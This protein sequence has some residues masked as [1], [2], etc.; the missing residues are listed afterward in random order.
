MKR[1]WLLAGTIGA[2]LL[3]AFDQPLTLAAGVVILLGFVAAG[4]VLVAAP[5][6]LEEDED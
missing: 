4:V 6:F 5:P 3:L 1:L 2:A